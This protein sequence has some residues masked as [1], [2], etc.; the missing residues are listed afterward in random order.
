MLIPRQHYWQIYPSAVAYKLQGHWFALSCTMVELRCNKTALQKYDMYEAI[1][2]AEQ[3]A[4][5]V[6][7]PNLSPGSTYPSCL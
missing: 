4:D 3:S 1:I 6:P 5:C 2:A 7:C